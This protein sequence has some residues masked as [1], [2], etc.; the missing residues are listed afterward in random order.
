MTKVKTT[1]LSYHQQLRD[2]RW[3]EFALKL[4]KESNWR[5]E[6]CRKAQGIVELSIHHT[7]YVS[8]MK[9]WEYPRCLLKCLCMSCHTERQSVEQQIYINVADV[10]RD[11]TTA[12]L[13]QQP[14]YAFFA[15]GFTLSND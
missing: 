6:E 8:G 14:I 10:M 7:Y 11:K 5:C 13:K 3:K 1:T 9:L 12:Q 15:D 2:P 4:K